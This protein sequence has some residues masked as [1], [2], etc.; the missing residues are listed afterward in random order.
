MGEAPGHRRFQLVTTPYRGVET[1]EW[2][3]ALSDGYVL[4]DADDVFKKLGRG[5]ATWGSML[6]TS[7]TRWGEVARALPYFEKAADLAPDDPMV[8]QNLEAARA[9]L[10][11][12]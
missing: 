1:R 10:T 3:R 2:L 5:W 9:A 8:L 4:F 7:F 11:G 12:R 6:E